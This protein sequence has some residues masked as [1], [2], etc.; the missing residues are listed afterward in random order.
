MDRYLLVVKCLIVDTRYEMLENHLNVVFEIWSTIELLNYSDN[1]DVRNLF[2]KRRKKMLQCNNCDKC[3]DILWH[4]CKMT[5]FNIRVQKCI[6]ICIQSVPKHEVALICSQ[7]MCTVYLWAPYT[8]VLYKC[9]FI[10]PGMFY[11]N[12]DSVICRK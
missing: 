1:H 9:T 5:C 8:I 12:R 3:L 10:C 7:V 11:V 6:K 4:Y 2:W